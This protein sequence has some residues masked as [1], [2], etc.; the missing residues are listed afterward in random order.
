MG[1]KHFEKKDSSD[2]SGDEKE[3]KKP[4]RINI[5]M[6]GYGYHVK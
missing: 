2:S 1:G 4:L 3:T 6:A 5:D